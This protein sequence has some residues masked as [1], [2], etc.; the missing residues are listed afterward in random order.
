MRSSS[1]SSSS[2][3]ASRVIYGLVHLFLLNLEIDLVS[4]FSS[5]SIQS[6]DIGGSL[7]CNRFKSLLYSQTSASDIE[8][9]PLVASVKISKTVEVFSLVKEMEAAGEKVTSL[10]VG[11]PDF[12]PPQA[13]L[14]AAIAAIQDGQTRYTAVTGTAS[15]RKAISDDL[16]KRKGVK[17]AP[18]NIVVGNGA[19]Q[20]VYQGVL[21]TCGPGDEVIIPAPYWPS[22]P[23]MVAV[24][25]DFVGFVKKS[26]QYIQPTTKNYILFLS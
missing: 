22:Y 16:D 21:A 2:F 15:L 7:R 23:E 18:E 24:S 12:P 1:S 11:E 25:Y 26:L 19:K 14:D 6:N 13:V 5:K 4:P 3:T 20:C 9:N 17:Y 8:L 10:C